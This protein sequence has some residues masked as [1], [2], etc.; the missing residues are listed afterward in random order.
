MKPLRLIL[1]TVLTLAA[2]SAL[3]IW[4]LVDLLTVS[5]SE[6]HTAEDGTR[7]YDF[8]PPLDR[9]L[10]AD[11]KN[12]ADISK[13][14]KVQ[15]KHKGYRRQFYIERPARM[16]EQV[17]VLLVLHGSGGSATQ[18]HRLLGKAFNELVNQHGVVVI[19]ADGFGGG[20]NDMR[21]QSPHIAK[22]LQLDDVGYFREVLN[23]TREKLNIDINGSYFFGMSNGAQMTMRLLVQA[24]ELVTAAVV[25][26]GNLPKNTDFAEN[27]EQLQARP[28]MFVHGTADDVVPYQ[29]GKVKL[30]K[31]F[32]FGEVYSAEETVRRWVQAAGYSGSPEQ[33]H[34]DNYD[35]N[36]SIDYMRWQGIAGA[37]LRAYRVNG[38]RH[39]FPMPATG[40]ACDKLISTSHD[41]NTIRTAWTFFSS[42][43]LAIGSTPEINSTSDQGEK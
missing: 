1:F 9:W 5:E 3:A 2:L 29:G 32:D 41:M 16:P 11:C 28:V 12:T 8:E 19:Y 14:E 33:T 35:D 22:H 31:L 10:L 26:G 39:T 34:I 25:I 6:L 36:T 38:G 40:D 21:S 27:Y 15:F 7:Y 23:I 4:A 43:S 20:W 30:L 13:L 42:Q 17:A 24:P 18:S 37:E